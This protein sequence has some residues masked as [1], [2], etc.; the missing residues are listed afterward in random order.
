MKRPTLI[1]NWKQ[2][3]KLHCV[4]IAAVGT[5]LSWA[6]SGLSAVYGATDSIQHAM[7]P[8]WAT[9]LILGCIFVGV[10]VGRILHQDVT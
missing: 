2:A 10:I 4:R 9:D 5:V 7:L 6:A 1:P 3:H 8:G